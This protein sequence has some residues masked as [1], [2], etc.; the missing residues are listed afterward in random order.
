MNKKENDGFIKLPSKTNGQIVSPQALLMYVYI[1]SYLKDEKNYCWPSLKKLEIDSGI[2]INT[3]KKYTQQLEDAGYLTI[4]KELRKR[5]YIFPDKKE[6]FE[7]FDREFLYNKELTYT[8]KAYL[9]ANQR[10]MFK[11]NGEGKIEY[12]QKEIS[13]KIHMPYRTV[14]DQNRSL[15]KKDFATIRELQTLDPETGYKN[16][17]FV[18][19]LS[20]V[21][22]K[23][24][25]HEKRIEA[26]EEDI[27]MIKE[28]NKEIK[29]ENKNLRRKYAEMEARLNKLE[30]DKN[31]ILI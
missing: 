28:E 10:F 9:V 22:Q 13:E 3:I 18:Y 11:E 8:E 5:T 30:Q 27:E 29:E 21:G 24:W 7:K 14:V 4:K 17:H 23:F 19:F 31:I 26:N 15:I 20:K 16:K 25:E 1:R 12:S 2:S 6:K